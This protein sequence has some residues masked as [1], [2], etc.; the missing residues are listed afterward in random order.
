VNAST[1][2]LDWKE[3]SGAARHKKSMV[4]HPHCNDSYPSFQN[5]RPS[6]RQVTSSQPRAS[7]LSSQ[8]LSIPARTSERSN[9]LGEFDMD[10]DQPESLVTEGTTGWYLLINDFLQA[11][12]T[13]STIRQTTFHSGI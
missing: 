13:F 1:R 10:V 5:L 7:Q 4:K 2:T 3:G 12:L 6:T 9:S 8:T 11:F